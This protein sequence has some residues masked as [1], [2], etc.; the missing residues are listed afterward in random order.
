MHGDEMTHGILA[1]LQNDS[2]DILGHPTGRILLQREP[3]DLDH[4]VIFKTAAE[5]HVALE[6]TGDPSRLD[7]PD[8]LCR[9][10]KEYGITFSACSDAHAAGELQQMDLAI[11]TARRG[12]IGAE[13]ILNTR[14]LPGL[15][16]RLRI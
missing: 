13:E 10:A 6:I 5:Q 9:K 3:S 16:N 15:R 7:L 8:V 14:P 1:A 12:W 2:V 4:P 11:A